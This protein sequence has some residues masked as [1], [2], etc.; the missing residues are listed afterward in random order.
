M[1]KF[2]KS[3]HPTIGHVTTLDEDRIAYEETNILGILNY[4]IGRQ[5]M[6]LHDAMVEV[7]TGSG[8]LSPTELAREINRRKLYTR[9][10]GRPVPPSQISARASKSNYC[11]MFSRE[12]G[13]IDVAR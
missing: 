4:G 11:H 9:G 13:K 5:I 12:L 1:K 8:A 3:L 6:T 7:L 2:N 10:D